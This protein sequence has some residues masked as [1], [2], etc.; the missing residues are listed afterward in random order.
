MNIP[1]ENASFKDFENIEGQNIYTTASQFKDYLDFLKV[2]GHL[3]YRIESLSPCGPEMELLLPGDD[4][5][6]RCVCLVSNDYLGFSQHPKIKAAVIDGVQRFGTGSGA[7]PAIGG[8]F[9]YHQQ[10]EEKIAGFYKKKDAILYTTGYTANSATLQCLLHK[11]DLAILDMSVH[12]SVYEG[13]LKTNVKTFLHNNME[14]LEQVLKNAQD[15][16]R[17][18]MVVIDGVYSQDG[19]IACLEK[20]AELTHKYGAYLVVDDAHGIGVVGDTGRGVI[21]MFNAFDQ[22]DI[23]TGTFSKALGN[24]GGYVIAGNEIITYLKFQSK[25]H[26]FSTTATPAVMGILK[27]ID[28]IDEEPQWRAKLWE[29]IDYIKQGLI[30]LGFDVGTTASAVIPV[31]VGDIPKTLEA[32]RLLLKLGV[33]TNPIMYPAVSKKNSRIRL[34]VM[35]GHTVAQLDRVLAAFKQVDEQLDISGNHLKS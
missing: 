13:C 5:P 29:N 11:E 4:A 24:I 12:A 1:Y 15:K 21:E 10:L 30:S 34:N 22:V 28:L 7:S 20:I 16:Y 2:N 23:I 26:L 8:H 3:N 9:V 31:K 32:G 18:K 14:M 27:A 25:Q 35:A 17:T 19:D 33:Y 6:T